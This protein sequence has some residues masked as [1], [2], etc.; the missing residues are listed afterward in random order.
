MSAV[1]WETRT[2]NNVPVMEMDHRYQTPRRSPLGDRRRPPNRVGY[3]LQRHGGSP[4]GKGELPPS[5]PHRPG[6]D[7]ARWGPRPPSLKEGYG[8]GRPEVVPQDDW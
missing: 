6:Q 5:V 8:R 7:M 4:P 2:A 1:R 3:H